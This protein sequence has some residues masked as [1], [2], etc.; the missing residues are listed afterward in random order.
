MQNTVQLK[1]SDVWQLHMNIVRY[2]IL[3][4]HGTGSWFCG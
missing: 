2:N 3:S 4:K 1:Q